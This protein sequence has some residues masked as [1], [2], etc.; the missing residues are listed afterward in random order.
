[1]SL[2][3]AFERRIFKPLGMTHTSL[4]AANDSSIPDL[5]PQGY[6]FGTN[7]ATINSHELPKT[8]QPGALAGTLKPIDE[9]DANPSW[10]W[11]AGGAISTAG[12]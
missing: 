10:A 1:M 5:H 2:S 3:D 4:P 11:A 7:V 12:D 9:T 6:Q 8:Q